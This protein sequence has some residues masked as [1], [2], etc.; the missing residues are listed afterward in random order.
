MELTTQQIIGLISTVVVPLVLFLGTVVTSRIGLGGKIRETEYAQKR[1]QL[2]KELA[3]INE[4]SLTVPRAAELQ[5]EVDR[6]ADDFIFR[7]ADAAKLS[8]AGL[9]GDQPEPLPKSAGRGVLGRLISML[10]PSV[11]WGQF[12]LIRKAALALVYFYHVYLV[13]FAL[14]V[15]LLE[16]AVPSDDPEL[17]LHL[18]D[19]IFFYIGILILLLGST[20]VL[21]ANSRERIAQKSREALAATSRPSDV[22]GS[23]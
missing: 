22:P 1:V 11:A 19:F 21:R 10:F 9:H 17:A 23:K 16:F 13:L 8:A 12:S 14:A 2:I 18:S 20:L 15:P 6:I 3:T 7:E 5:R 4:A